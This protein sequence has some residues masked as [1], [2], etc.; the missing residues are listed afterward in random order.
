MRSLFFRIV[1]LLMFVSGGLLLHG[2]VNTA[3]LS[4]L[5]TDQ[6]GAILSNVSVQVTDGATGYTRLVKTDAAGLYSFQDLPIGQ[7]QVAVSITGFRSETAQITLQVGEKARQDFHLQIG[8]TQ[9]TVTVQAAA[10]MLSPDDASIGTVITER[11]IEKTPL[12]LRNWDDLLRLV[13]GVQISRYTQQSGNTAAGRTGDFNVNGVHSLQNDFIL[14]GID[15]NTFSENVQE[16]STEASHPSVDTIAQFN[17]ITN[18]YS[19]EYGRSPGAV[20]SVN[21]KSGTNK[22]HGVAYEYVRNNF[23][24]A[25]DFFSDRNGLPKPEDNQNQFGA[26]LGG[27]I[28]RNKLFFFFDYEGTRIKQ[29]VSRIATVPLPNE[30][31]GDFSPA[32]AAA[33]G[34]TYPT[35]YDPTTC[36]PAYS[37]SNCQP[38][39]D[40]KIPTG[41]I[42]SAVAKLMALFPLPNTTTPGSPADLNNFT[43]NAQAVDN[44]DSYDGRVDWTASPT[45]NLF[46]RYNYSTR[47]RAIP[48]YLGGLADGTSTSAW[49]NQTLI[50]YSTVLGWTHILSQSMVNEFRFG[51]VRNYSYAVQQPFNLSQMAGDFVPGIP[52][53]PATGGGIPLTTFSNYAFEG[54]PDYLPKQ[55]VPMQYQYS[56]TFSMV[57]GRQS[58]K[59]GISLYLPMRNLFQDEEGTRGDLGFTGV[60]TCQ[61]TAPGKCVSGTGLSYADG[62]LGATE[63]TQLTNVFFVDQRL[64]MASGFVEDDWKVTPQLTFNLGLRYDFA[65]PPY[66]GRNRMADF[67]PDSGSLVFAKSGSLQDRTI[68]QPNTKDFGPR[69]GF[70]F[71]PNTKT[72]IRGG[73]GVYYTLLER[74]GSEDQLALNPPNLVNKAPAS[75]ITPVLTPA[76]G[77]PSNFLDPSAINFNNLTA[78]HIRSVPVNDPD[79]SVQQWS[80]GVQREFGSAWVAEVDYV[81]TKSTHLDV[82]RNYN[83]PLIENNVS[84]GT[85]PYTNFGQ[86]EWTSPI[87][88]GNYNGLQA[89]LTRRFSNG[90]NLRAA[91]TH[92]RS[93]D[94]TPEELESNSG[95]APNG[96]DYSAWYGPSDFDVPNRIAV[97]Y[98]YELPFG[99]GK[100]MLN[101]G[102]AAWV[103]GG[104]Q[105][106]GV[107][108]YYSGHPFQI[109]ENDGQRNAALDPYGYTTAVPNLIGTAHIVG[110]PTCW[111]YASKNTACA[112]HSPASY[113]D[114]YAVTAVGAI[115]NV[116]RNTLRGPRTDVFDANLLREFP[117]GDRWNVEARWEV[118]NV[119]NTPEFGQPQGNITSGGVASITTLSGDPRVMQL[120]LRLSW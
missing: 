70:A 9:Q 43:R 49:G 92:S 22:F 8:S 113:T 77:F 4:G 120:A 74:I 33:V 45:D 32:T 10:P 23:F 15:N 67:D 29:G 75:S 55:Q 109:N 25:N 35:I 111:F 117:F 21:T 73:Y 72:V 86:I 63:S 26:N 7:Y 87:G 5:A 85:V 60:F 89:S 119:T 64:W 93:L 118:F 12:Y 106:S 53:S 36:A 37:G 34:V 65:S 97:S 39:N 71:S 47:Y 61:H 115:G 66:E 3:S 95:D 62:L 38:F 102:P 105:T 83:Q 14:D 100:P 11:T 81:G 46:V 27:P 101:H 28:L 31:T 108:T 44:D 78:F 42:D 79:P 103:L 68:V 59:A 104:W 58:I 30:R 94:N 116:G 107:Y 18:P 51:W 76:I 99:H 56:D 40:N 90:W 57:H 54:S 17:I 24:D 20:V 69:V 50:D 82:I 98:V 16:L 88:H 52:N 41:R 1:F 13:P 2:Q 19:A 110:D 91:F 6:T 48:G 112:G 96:R 84:T 114:A 80:L